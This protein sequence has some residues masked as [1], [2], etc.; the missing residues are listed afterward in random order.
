MVGE[1]PQAE[2]PIVSTIRAGIFKLIPRHNALA[3]GAFGLETVPLGPS[4]FA[5]VQGIAFF[6]SRACA[7]VRS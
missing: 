5:F 7:R 1:P 2:V 6:L 4:G 3:T